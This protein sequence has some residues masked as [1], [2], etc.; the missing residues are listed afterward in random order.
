MSR[1]ERT[2]F[3]IELFFG[4]WIEKFSAFQG[5]RSEHEVLLPPLSEFEV[6][7]VVKQ[8]IDPKETSSLEKS[9]FPDV[10]QLKQINV[11]DALEE[12]EAMQRER[13]KQKQV[14]KDAELAKTLQEQIRMEE[15][16]AREKAQRESAERE[17]AE[18]ERGQREKLERERKRISQFV[19][20]EGWNV[21]V[22]D[23]PSLQA[24]ILNDCSTGTLISTEGSITVDAD[25]HKWIKREGRQE[26]MMCYHTEWGVVMV[27]R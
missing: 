19:V 3:V 5:V 2:I 17:R 27:E 9:G 8:I 6:V 10:I 23:G 16:A 24:K 18:L 21:N 4:Y 25:G 15:E 26:Y 13:A 11:Q 12:R 7:G 1:Q 22:R 14:Q 20:C